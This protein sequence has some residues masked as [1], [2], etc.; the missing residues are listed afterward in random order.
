MNPVELP[1]MRCDRCDNGLEPEWQCCPYCCHVNIEPDT[2]YC[3]FCSTDLGNRNIKSIT[4]L[5]TQYEAL[6]GAQDM[7]YK[8]RSVLYD[9]LNT[10][11]SLKVERSIAALRAAGIQREK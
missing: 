7:L 10:T 9:H 6:M 4:I 5:R 3:P 1:Q 11:D 2:I 8:Y